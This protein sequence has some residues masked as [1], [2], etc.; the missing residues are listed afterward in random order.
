[1]V[2]PDLIVRTHRRSLCITVTKDG[3][4]VVHAPMRLNM[5]DIIKYILGRIYG[6][7]KKKKNSI[8]R[9]S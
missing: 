2:K 1:M 6:K 3:S 7:E 4:L 8:K 5:N 9:F